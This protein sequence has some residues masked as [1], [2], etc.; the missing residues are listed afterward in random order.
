M[1]TKSF[2]VRPAKILAALLISIS[3][4]GGA[5]LLQAGAASSET[6]AS[7]AQVRAAFLLA[8]RVDQGIG[9]PQLARAGDVPSDE[10]LQK[11]ATDGTAAV[12]SIFADQPAAKVLFALDNAV[13]SQKTSRDKARILGAGIGEVKYQ[14]VT[15]DGKT[16]TVKA[17]VETWSRTMLKGFDGTWQTYEPHNVLDVSMTFAMNDNQQWI[18]QTYDW[19][20]APSGGP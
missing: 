13:K 12:H 4:G 8:M 17:Y 14:S 15:V 2:V 20:F 5:V 7:E 10:A 19:S 6:V 11:Q 18:V 16:A 3:V 9:V 1:S